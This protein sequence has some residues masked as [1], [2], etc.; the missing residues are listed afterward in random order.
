VPI[1]S[2]SQNQKLTKVPVAQIEM[3]DRAT[4]SRVKMRDDRI[5]EYTESI[6]RG[7]DLF[8]K[9]ADPVRLFH[10]GMTYRIADGWHRISAAIRVGWTQ[11]PAVVTAGGKDDAIYVAVA[12]NAKHGIQRTNEDKRRAVLLALQHPK[13]R[14]LSDRGLARHVDVTHPFVALQRKALSDREQARGGN[15]TTPTRP[16]RPA[17]GRTIT[18][19]PRDE[20]VRGVIEALRSLYDDKIMTDLND[21]AGLTLSDA[22]RADLGA[23]AADLIEDLTPFAIA[24]ERDADPTDA[25]EDDVNAL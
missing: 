19:D 9:V 23:I 18:R 20:K 21:L 17:G 11:V 12:A 14:R 3:T 4:Q 24:Q 16:R 2:V 6:E 7:A 15:V 5:T 1:E 8:E 10:D 22:D 13:L 25:P